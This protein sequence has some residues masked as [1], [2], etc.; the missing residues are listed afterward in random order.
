VIDGTVT[1]EGDAIRGL[2]QGST[3]G[4]VGTTVDGFKLI[5]FRI[6]QR[7]PNSATPLNKILNCNFT[8]STFLAF[9]SSG[10][11]TGYWAINRV[12][13]SGCSIYLKWYSGNRIFSDFG[14]SSIEASTIGLD[15][16]PS[17]TAISNDT[18]LS[19]KNCIFTSNDSGSVLT[20]SIGAKGNTCCF[21]NWGTTTSGGTNNIFQDPQL[22][23]LTGGDLRLRPT[24]PCI[25]VATLS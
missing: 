18:L 4:T 21:Y 10:A 12:L 11:I 14:G 20:A 24:S 7:M 3:S 6:N 13:V 1:S 22:V 16:H 5:D 9:G 19:A 15:I 17:E 23:N 2:Q 25:G 8:C